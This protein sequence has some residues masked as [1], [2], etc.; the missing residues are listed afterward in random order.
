[1]GLVGNETRGNAGVAL[2][3]SGYQVRGRYRRLRIRGRKD[4]VE[5]VAIPAMCGF[6][7]SQCRNLRVEGVMVGLELVLVAFA[8]SGAGLHLPRDHVRIGN[9]VGRMT[10]GT[11]RRAG[12]TGLHALP[13]NSSQVGFLSARMARSAG[14]RHVGAIGAAVRVALG[15]NFMRAMTTR[16]ARRHQQAILSKRESVDRIHVLRIH[17]FESMALGELQIAMAGSAGARQV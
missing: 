6:H 16:A 8:A 4:F 14:A 1:M 10:T 15:Q 3:A 13:M 5:T 9:L 12:I 17:L 2:A 11:N 7:V